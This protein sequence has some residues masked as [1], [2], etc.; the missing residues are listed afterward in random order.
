MDTLT[1]P[2]LRRLR[3]ETWI[4]AVHKAQWFGLSQ[5]DTHTSSADYTFRYVYI[6]STFILCT[7]YPECMEDNA[8]HGIVHIVTFDDFNFLYCW[9]FRMA[10]DNSLK[11]P[12]CGRVMHCNAPIS[13]HMLMQEQMKPSL[14]LDI[15]ASYFV[16][17]HLLT[18]CVNMT[19]SLPTF[20]C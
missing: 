5:T 8:T 19:K 2:K 14:H 11:G 1:W 10:S 12:G 16:V 13:G 20:Q 17:H 9:I 7:F 4:P 3:F 18:G 6:V 15:G